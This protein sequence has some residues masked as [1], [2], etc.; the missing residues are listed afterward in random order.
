MTQLH[1]M[2]NYTD[3]DVVFHMYSCSIARNAWIDA[4]VSV[5]VCICACMHEV[6]MHVFSYRIIVLQDFLCPMAVY[7]HI[8]RH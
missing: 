7:I 3:G 6:H 5:C 1:Y 8:T 4:C 2:Y